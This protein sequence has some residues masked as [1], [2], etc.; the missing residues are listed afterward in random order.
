[1]AKAAN[2]TVGG[3]RSEALGAVARE[4]TAV[5]T[6]TAAFDRI[7]DERRE[8]VKLD[9]VRTRA[10]TGM[11]TEEVQ[12]LTKAHGKDHPRVMRV[13]A[14][15]K[16]VERQAKSA[17]AL[18]RRIEAMT[19]PAAGGWTA[20]GRVREAAG[21][22]L[23][24]VEVGFVAATGSQTGL[25]PTQ[26]DEDGEFYATYP[27]D[28]V[29][30]LIEAKAQ[31]SLVVRKGRTIIHRDPET[32]LLQVNAVRQFRVEIPSGKEPPSKEPP[33]KVPPSKVPP[34]KASPKQR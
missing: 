7:E 4:P 9:A 31:F 24:G 17:E 18:A 16:S 14:V 2:R 8:Q 26:T 10:E 32:F 23:A 19:L 30:K 25:E 12:R 29:K 13:T 20:T 6:L 22:P 3:A 15:L 21:K 1:M 5:A 28:V 34:S 27:A 11:L 33:S